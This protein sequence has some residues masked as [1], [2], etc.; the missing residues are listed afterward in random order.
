MEQYERYEMVSKLTGESV[1]SF[2]LRIE[3][4]K[5]HLLLDGETIDIRRIDVTPEE[6]KDAEEF[7][8]LLKQETSIRDRMSQLVQK[9]MG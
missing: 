3:E 7:Y 9:I 1:G 6:V 4:N 8:Q 5:T 2:Y